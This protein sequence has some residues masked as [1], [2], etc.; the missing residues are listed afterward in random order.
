MFEILFLFLPKRVVDEDVLFVGVES[1]AVVPHALVQSQALRDLGVTG[2]LANGASG[3]T[4]Q[5]KSNYRRSTFLNHIRFVD[6]RIL[7]I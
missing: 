4:I 7:R 5:T 6:W 1:A 2:N 3:K